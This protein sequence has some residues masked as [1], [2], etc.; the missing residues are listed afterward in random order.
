MTLTRLLASKAKKKLDKSLQRKRTSPLH[1]PEILGH[2]FLYLSSHQIRYSVLCVCKQWNTVG[3]AAIP[4]TNVWSEVSAAHGLSFVE[5]LLNSGT[6]TLQCVAPRELPKMSSLREYTARQMK[7]ALLE[8]VIAT[9]PVQKIRRI[10]TVIMEGDVN[11][12][13]NLYPILAIFSG[14]KA[15]RLENLNVYFVQLDTILHKCPHLTELHIDQLDPNDISERRL[16][17]EQKKAP[18]PILKLRSLTLWRWRIKMNRLLQVLERCPHMK[19]LKLIQ[20]HFPRISDQHPIV[21]NVNLFNEIAANCPQIQSLHFSSSNQPLNGVLFGRIMDAF[22]NLKSWSAGIGDTQ[23]WM[24]SHLQSS[25]AHTLT[26]LEIYDSR[27]AEYS[28]TLAQGLHQ[29]LCVAT[30]LLHLR[31][32]GVVFT[33]DD[34]FVLDDVLPTRSSTD[35]K[36]K[37]GTVTMSKHS[38]RIWACRNLRTLRLGFRRTENLISLVQLKCRSLFAYIANVC[39]RLSELWIS[40]Y[41]LDFS[42]KGGFCLL[43]GLK[44]LERLDIY[45]TNISDDKFPKTDIEWI[46]TDGGEI[47]WEQL[48]GVQKI[49]WWMSLGQLR[50]SAESR[51]DSRRFKGT[52]SHVPKGSKG[53]LALESDDRLI[54]QIQKASCLDNVANVMD[55]LRRSND[56][57]WPFLE[58]LTIDRFASAK[59]KLQCLPALIRQLRPELEHAH[60]APS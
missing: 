41:S 18:L 27:N 36:P 40:H 20:L 35:E 23:P 13:N 38:K 2:V 7:W 57:C 6:D 17:F 58:T 11:L 46:R 60:E 33:E 14:L 15:L 31:A 56:R 22:P 44:E 54:Y 55:D 19:E 3:R 50:E 4:C 48:P 49:K 29:F 30:S 43:S 24:Y 37:S 16:Y 45:S 21:A 1:V 59:S 8:S 39:P 26:S 42:V 28:N 9:L 47:P 34:I 32:D 5:Y 10:K 52:T 25:M 12:E 53:R 51:I